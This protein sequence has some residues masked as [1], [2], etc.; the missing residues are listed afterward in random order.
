MS[1]KAESTKNYDKQM[2]N[3][4]NI[5][6]KNQSLIKSSTNKKH[7]ITRELDSYVLTLPIEKVISNKKSQNEVIGGS[8]L[9]YTQKSYDKIN[10]KHKHK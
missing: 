1:N 8:Y 6:R 9:K 2:L 4:Q 3:K 10:N 5:N 7:K